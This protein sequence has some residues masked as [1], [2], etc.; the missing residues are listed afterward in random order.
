M[1]SCEVTV[2]SPNDFDEWIGQ[3]QNHHWRSIEQAR[4][5]GPRQR[6]RP[7]TRGVVF[8]RS[9]RN[10]RIRLHA[11]A[12]RKGPRAPRISR[13]SARQLRAAPR[14]DSAR[15]S[16]Q[17]LITGSEGGPGEGRGR[18][19]DLQVELQERR[20]VPPRARRRD[21]ELRLSASFLPPGGA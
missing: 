5:S 7:R 4:R 18:P 14:A 13:G 12:S 10:L 9:G 11:R 15:L 17:K 8:K 21:V 6:R 2:F 1:G 3:S 16:P 20:L 19:G